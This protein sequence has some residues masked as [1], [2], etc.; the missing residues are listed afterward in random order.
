MHKDFDHPA[1]VFLIVFKSQWLI[2]EVVIVT[3]G[4][5]YDEEQ[6]VPSTK[7]ESERFCVKT[8]SVH[9]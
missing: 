6:V 2:A 9:D 5:E 8:L 7:F 1:L 3:S 4:P